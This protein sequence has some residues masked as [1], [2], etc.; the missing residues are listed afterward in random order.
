MERHYTKVKDLIKLSELK[1]GS[2]LSILIAKIR[3]RD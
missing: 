2:K 3:E 1:P